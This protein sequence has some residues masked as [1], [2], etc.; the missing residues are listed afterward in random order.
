[1]AFYVSQFDV[2]AM[3]QRGFE[4]WDLEACLFRGAG[5]GGQ[6][7]RP[8]RQELPWPW[9]GGLWVACLGVELVL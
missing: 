2:L 4:G 5:L 6:G 7:R 3:A 1:V 8:L 9:D